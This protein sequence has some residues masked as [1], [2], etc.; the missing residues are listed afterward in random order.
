M[1]GDEVKADKE[2]PGTPSALALKEVGEPKKNA[3]DEELV[4]HAEKYLA[5][6]L[7]ARRG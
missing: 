5:A 4:A 6:K 3:S 7:K 1:A 2:V